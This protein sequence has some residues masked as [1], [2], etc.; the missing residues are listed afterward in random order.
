MGKSST[1]HGAMEILKWVGDA[2]GSLAQNVSV[3]T[4][5]VS[6]GLPTCVL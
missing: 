4:S 1:D 2:A 3:G 6:V 5:T